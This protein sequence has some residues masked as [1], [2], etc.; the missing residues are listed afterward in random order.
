[1][2]IEQPTV[3]FR[4]LQ[5]IPDQVTSF[6][7]T[8]SPFEPSTTQEVKKAIGK[9]KERKAPGPDGVWASDVKNQNNE[10]IAHELNRMIAD[11]DPR[12]TEGYIVLILKPAKKQ[13]ELTSYRPITIL[14]VRRK[15]F[16]T[17]VLNRIRP[18]LDETTSHLQH[19]Y[20]IGK[21]TTD[22]VLAYKLIKAAADTF[23]I[24]LDIAGVDMSK[25]FD[26]VGRIKLLA[27]L[28]E[29]G[30]P[31]SEINIIA[32][33]L[34]NTT[35]HIKMGKKVGETFVVN[36]G[37]PHGDSLSPKLFTSY[38]NHALETLEHRRAIVTEE[39]DY[40]SGAKSEH[41]YAILDQIPW[42]AYIG[43]AD[44]LDFI[45]R[46][47]KESQATVLLAEEIFPTYNL[48]IN[49]AKTEFIT[50]GSENTHPGCLSNIKKK[51]RHAAR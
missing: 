15:L 41:D 20:T 22:V 32:V 36:I 8:D 30:T 18:I 23:E 10:E 44:N 6:C 47:R 1:M 3:N 33:L 34:S 5:T 24:E 46:T 40:T 29:I 39:H 48:K 12:L 17:I 25:A 21:S 51:A 19:A 16:S 13:S 42:P 50:I 14:N 45:G 49:L 27:N 9:L 38:L 37:V 35:F 31:E 26:T 4:K 2:L 11:R 43:Y 28:R 7:T